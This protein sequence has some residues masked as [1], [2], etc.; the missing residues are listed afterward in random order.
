MNILIDIEHYVKL[1]NIEK[2]KEKLDLYDDISTNFARKLLLISVERGYFELFKFLQERFKLDL[3]YDTN[4]LIGIAS[5]SNKYEI[6]K[7]LMKQPSVDPADDNNYALFMATKYGDAN[8]VKLLLSDSRVIKKLTF[9]QMERNGIL[10]YFKEIYG[11]D[12]DEDV[13]IILNIMM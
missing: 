4:Y 7:Y 9:D 12:S 1:N 6:V 11:I 3:G 8:L 10:G 2:V 13:K 5:F